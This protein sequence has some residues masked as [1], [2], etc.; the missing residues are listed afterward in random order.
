MTAAT[1]ALK[2]T[3]PLLDVAMRRLA[4]LRPYESPTVTGRGVHAE[5]GTQAW[6]QAET[7]EP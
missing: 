1:R 2:T 4:A 6:L 5:V 3:A 7:G